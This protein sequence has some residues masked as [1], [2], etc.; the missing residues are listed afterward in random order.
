MTH[1]SSPNSIDPRHLAVVGAGPR[2]GAAIGRGFGREGFHVT[3]LSR[4]AT[5]LDAV[6]NDV[7]RTGAQVGQIVADPAQPEQ[8]RATLATLY[9]SVGAP[10]RSSTTPRSSHRTACSPPTLGTS[11]RPTTSVSSAPSSQPR[12]P[13]P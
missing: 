9:R 8:L 6:G 4:G 11:T 10:G 13:P 3:L 5:S 7:R 12:S 2:L 1:P